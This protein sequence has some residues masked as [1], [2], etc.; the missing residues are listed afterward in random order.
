MQLYRIKNVN[1]LGSGQN[2]SS[3]FKI[4]V[5]Y[6]I[7][8]LIEH[9]SVPERIYIIFFVM[10]NIDKTFVPEEEHDGGHPEDG[11]EEEEGGDA[12]LK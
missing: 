3:S 4:A 6:H 7:Q 2:Y 12:E 5:Y 1:K 8:S 10:R 9:L 11:E